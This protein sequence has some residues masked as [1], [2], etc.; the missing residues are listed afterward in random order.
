MK[1]MKTGTIVAAAF[2]VVLLVAGAAVAITAQVSSHECERKA[3][4]LEVPYTWD[5]G[6][7]CYLEKESGK[8]VPANS[9]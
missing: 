2:S 3:K 4:K 7:G 1:P 6:T 9:L 8:W 5:L